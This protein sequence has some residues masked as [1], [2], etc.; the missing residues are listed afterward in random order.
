[1]LGIKGAS[2]QRAT[3]S[4]Q[5]GRPGRGGLLPDPKHP[6]NPGHNNEETS[7]C[8]AGY[9]KKVVSLK[10]QG[11]FADHKRNPYS[12]SLLILLSPSLSISPSMSLS[13]PT[14]AHVPVLSSSSILIFMQININILLCQG[15]HLHIDDTR[16]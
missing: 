15:A 16:S 9:N 14:C 7:G 1:M 3:S 5:L 4:R 6:M 8:S 11:R 12:I 10:M 13:C 2:K